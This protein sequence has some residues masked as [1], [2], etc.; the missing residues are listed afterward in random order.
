VRNLYAANAAAYDAAIETNA[1]EVLIDGEWFTSPTAVQRK[2]DALLTTNSALAGG[3]V[4]R[5]VGCWEIG[6][7]HASNPDLSNAFAQWIAAGSGTPALPAFSVADAS[8]ARPDASTTN[9]V[10]TVTLHPAATGAVSVAFFTAD[11]T[12]TAPADYFATNG[13][14]VFGAGQTSRPVPVTVLGRTNAGPN[15][16]LLLWL[17]NASGATLLRSPGTGTLLNLH[18]N[19]GGSGGGGNASI[20]GECALGQQWAVTYGGAAFRATL[21]LTNP[22]PTNITLRTFAFDAPYASVEW[23]AADVNLVNWVVP[24]RV[25]SHFT[26]ANGWT[27]PAVV[28][29]GGSL[30]LTFQGAPGPNPPAPA[31]VKVNGVT[32][33]DCGPPRFT[34]IARQGND[35]QLA[36]TT[37]AGRTNFVQTRTNAGTAT[38]GDLSGPLWIP[39]AGLITTGWTHAGA[40]TSAPARLYRIRIAP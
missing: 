37:S 19:G 7:E 38:W 29:A 23:I 1:L 12:A 33:G 39:G 25:G 35:V 16:T 6:H 21:T 18:T 40:T 11:G 20:G 22:N 15:Q 24:A 2:L 10:F 26:V 28:P 27:P 14:L 30:T 36:W 4:I 13:T 3:A 17:T 34:A 32:V 8:V 31:A 9:L 5:G